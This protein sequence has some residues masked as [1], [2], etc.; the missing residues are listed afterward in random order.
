MKKITYNH[1]ALLPLAA[2]LLVLA[3]CVDYGDATRPVSAKVQLTLPV[4]FVNGADLS[5]HTVTLTSG[6]RTLSAL[7]D[8]SGVAEFS[9]IVPDVYDLSASWNLTPEQYA[10]LTGDD[11][12]NEG[13]VVSGSIS[14][15]LISEAG[16]GNFLTLAMR[17]SINRSIVIGKLYYAGSKDN[18]NKNYLAGRY[19]ELYNQSDTAVNVAGLYL[20]LLDSG[21]TPAYSLANL[22][23]LYADT[24][25]MAKQIFRIPADREY[26]VEP[27][28]TV[29]ITNSA[30]DH[31]VNGPLEKNLLQADFECKD[32]QGRTQNNP[33]TPAMELVY[34]AFSGISNM[35]LIQAG[36]CSVVIF[37]TDDDVTAWQKVYAYGKTKG[38]QWLMLPVRYVIDGVEV[39]ANKRTGVEVGKKVVLN[40]IDAGYTNI[41]A[42]SG[43]TGEVVY[44]KASGRRG[45]NGHGILKDT[46]NSTDDFKT[47]TTI[48]IRE[49]D[50]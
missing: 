50:E 35:N 23:D 32:H 5:G 25:L 34:T 47:S 49:Y 29:V 21:S 38:T 12:V 8:A 18:N 27:G 2:L 31:T 11:V 37:R 48:G 9:G 26:W 16:A 42:T 41:E 3:S 46:N 13:A 45:S 14:N 15:Q 6:S 43:Y 7:T 20:G 1:A 33:A 24:V 39:L 17:L 4:E 40:S 44:R 19:V 30:I 22:H 36:P 28:G 10:A